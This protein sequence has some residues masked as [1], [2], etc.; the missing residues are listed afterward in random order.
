MSWPGEDWTA[1][2]TGHV[3][4]KVKQLQAQ[5]EKL[6]KERQQR[7]LQL[8]NSEAALH[9]QKQK[10]EEVRVELTAV[11]RE[12]G[13]ER[14]AAHAEVRVRERLS[15]DL[16]VKT[17]QV[18]SLEGQLE[19]SKNLIQ[20]LTQEIKRLEAELEKLQK[21]NGSGDS[22]L[23][24][25]PCWNMSSPR[26]HSGGFRAEGDVIAQ[27]VRQQ[28]QFGDIPK[29]VV[30]GA[31]SPFPQQPQRSPPLRR[32]VR[33]SEASTPSSVFP[34][35]RDDMWSTPK[36][37]PATSVASGDVIK[38]S[39][40]G[41][42]EA[43]RNEID[44]LRVRVSD[45]QREAQL[46]SEHLKDVES[47][48]AQAQRDINTKEQSL[49]R[50]QDQLTRAQTRI[51][52]ETDRVQAAEQKVKQLQE[53][54]KCQR[55]NAESSRCN[56]EQRRKDM[57]REH[58]RELLEQQRERQALEKQHQQEINRLNQE[59]QQAR[60]LHNTL[61]AQHDKV[62]LQKQGLE[63]DLEDVRGKL[64]N[65]ESDLRDSQKR[66]TQT[67]AKLTEALR[68]NENLTVSLGKMKKQ[69]KA[70]QEEVKRLTDELAEALKLIKELQ[71]QLAAPPQPVSV[72]HFSSTGDCFSPSVSI[73]QDRSPPYQHSTQRKRAP[74]TDR[75]REEERMKYPSGREPGEGID[76]EHIGSFGSEESQRF[77][78]KGVVTQQSSS[79][80]QSDTNMDISLEQD[81]GI[82]DV[83]TDSFMSDS[84]I[85]TMSKSESG[86]DRNLQDVTH[87]TMGNV[88]KLDSASLK[89]LKKENSE[90]RDELRDVKYELQ[91]RLEDLESQRRA[92]TEA[93]TKLK[94][95]SRKHS[96]QT[97]QQR[98][99][100]LEINDSVTKLEAQLE[101]EKKEN[102]KLRESLDVL[103]REAE[104][105]QEEKERDQDE[106]DELKE[107]LAEMEQKETSMEE[108]LKRVRKELEDL[109]L[110][111]EQEREERERERE[112]E[113]KKIRKEEAEGLKIAQ[114]QEEL[115]NLRR[116]G[117]LEEKISQENVPVAYLQLDRHLNTNNKDSVP[118]PESICDSVNLH[119]T[120]ICKETRAMELIMDLG[121]Q[122]K[123]AEPPGTTTEGKTEI[124]EPLAVSSETTDLDDTTIL[125]LEIERLRV[126]REQESE[127]AKLTQGKLED[128]QKQVNTQ[129][130]HL[131][132]AFE[133]QSKNIENLLRELHDKECALQRQAEELQKCQEKITLFEEAQHTSEDV[134]F[135]EVST[136]LE[137]S[138]EIS[139][140]LSCDSVISNMS[141]SDQEIFNDD[142]P[143]IL[144]D[145]QLSLQLPVEHSVSRN[146]EQTN[147]RDVSDKLQIATEVLNAH[148]LSLNCECPPSSSVHE[149]S[150]VFTKNAQETPQQNFSITSSRTQDERS[151]VQNVSEDSTKDDSELERVMKDLQE[152]EFQLN[153]LKTQNEA[154]GLVKEEVLSVRR[155]NEELK[156]KLRCLE[157]DTCADRTSKQDEN[158][159]LNKEVFLDGAPSGQEESVVPD[160]N[161]KDEEIEEMKET[162]E[163]HALHKQIQTLQDQLQNLSEQNRTQAEELNLW[164]ISSMGETE[165]SSSPSITLREFE[166]FLPCNSIK[167]CTQQTRTTDV[168]HQCGLEGG[169]ELTETQMTH[170]GSES[171]GPA[172]GLVTKSDKPM[173][174]ENAQQCASSSVNHSDGS[175]PVCTSDMMTSNT[176]DLQ[177]I[178]L[179]SPVYQSNTTGAGANSQED[180][181]INIS[182]STEYLTKVINSKPITEPRENRDSQNSDLRTARNQIE[183]TETVALDKHGY[184]HGDKH[185]SRHTAEVGSALHTSASSKGQRSEN[186][187]VNGG[188]NR[189]EIREVECV[190]TQTEE[191]GEP[192]DTTVKCS[193]VHIST[194]TDN[195][196]L[197]TEEDEGRE[198]PADSPPLSHPH[199]SVTNQLLLSK[200]FP[201]SDPAHLAERI[202]QN[203]NRMS[204]AY[205]DTEYEPYGLPEVVMKGFADIPSGPACP[206][207][208]RRG[209][210]GTDAMPLPLKEATPQ[211]ENEEIEP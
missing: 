207:V 64:K 31:S 158:N 39:D 126:E 25:T 140:E 72:P 54:L 185:N 201:M 165:D 82:E 86:V 193:L 12:L 107:V 100:A 60:T 202:R 199:Q 70:V 108:E 157:K 129:T 38:S 125:V 146:V 66:E 170:V 84:T 65:T 186:C 184:C 10:Y 57:E 90:L 128:L 80:K 209:L 135:S 169:N 49:T 52:Q 61:Q 1:G 142:T 177:Q 101:Q 124:E 137:P 105:R 176:K 206:Y 172:E 19:S 156:A 127:K 143:Q 178:A 15:H 59:I 161:T 122:T 123:P 159:D 21:G 151:E 189:K 167:P 160:E 148:E 179:M 200:A 204:A 150:Q 114:L 29:P 24:S 116:F 203:R 83:D 196:Q 45:L 79:L 67:E 81:T 37:R 23:F 63:R 68:E 46:E 43:L 188:C 134:V 145:S 69:E 141:I 183:T 182:I 173:I 44:G 210:L 102:T 104:K 92:E 27:H 205:D 95:L 75:T 94:Q 121:A 26:D 56:A 77:R 13:G 4:Q 30:G 22:M 195:V 97:E 117:H 33:Q 103:E 211:D 130:K 51:T 113:R 16:E 197:E 174:T 162:A 190:S 131:T 28:L 155:E 73:H 9:K 198:E 48:L 115:D 164:K 40:S 47:R 153:V 187:E 112:E 50:T 7:Q 71:A 20:S 138:T 41:I 74:Q 62:C 76:S 181:L 149:L 78:S 98:A 55:Q 118:S 14:E 111:H 91:K 99:K 5:N 133:S 36:G 58:Q 8:D 192:S 194:Q 208:L 144:K 88:E 120:M 132:H 154:L 191:S 106:S 85:G 166:I 147:T 18:H 17:A 109:Q 89:D 163:V 87:D 93:R 168:T 42:E 6:T 171:Q 32:H 136:H 180:A 96:T 34:W 3:L 139:R 2:L 110:Q 152:A 11:Q 119:N 53:E 35:E 175:P